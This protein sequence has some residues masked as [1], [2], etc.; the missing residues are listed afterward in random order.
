MSKLRAPTRLLLA[1]TL[2]FAAT[3]AHAGMQIAGTPKVRFDATGTVMDLQWVGPVGQL[4]DYG[5]PLS[6]TVPMAWSSYTS[7]SLDAL[8]SSAFAESTGGVR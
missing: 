3:A 5:Q 4:V 8:P 1:L 6:F 2:P 7:H